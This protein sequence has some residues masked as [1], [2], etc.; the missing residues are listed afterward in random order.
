MLEGIHIGY[1]CSGEVGV[2]LRARASRN[3]LLGLDSHVQ[4]D[5]NQA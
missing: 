2:E 1:H 4:L 3:G 5:S